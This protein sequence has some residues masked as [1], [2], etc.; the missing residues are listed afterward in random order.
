MNAIIIGAGPAGLTAAYELLTRTSIKPIVLE[1]SSD[2]GGL[3]KTVNHN[4]NR[5]DI[6]GHRFFSKSDR[7]MD[8]W[9]RFLPLQ[10]VE[11]SEEAIFYQGGKREV[12]GSGSGPDP[13]LEDDVMLLRKRA[14]RIYYLAKLFPYPVQPGLDLALKL[15]IKRSVAILASYLRVLVFPPRQVK[16]LEEFFISRFGKKLYETFFKSYTEKVWGVPCRELSAD[17]GAQRVKKLSITKAIWHSLRKVWPFRKV[18]DRKQLETSLIEQFLYPKFGPGQMWET[19]AREIIRLG[20]VIHRN[21]EVRTVNLQGQRVLSLEAGTRGDPES[22]TYQADY[23]ISTMPIKELMRA[24][25]PAPPQEMA[26]ISEGLIYRDFVTVGLLL[27]HL[28]LGQVGD[29][30]TVKDN[31]IYIHEPSVEAGRLQIFNNWSPYM[32][33]DP[34][35]AWVGVEYFCNEGDRIWSRSDA[36][37]IAHTLDELFRIGIIDERRASDAVVV[38]MKKAYPAYRGTYARFGELRRHL[39][40]IENLYLV[41]RNGMHRYN[42]QDHSMLTA[43]TAVD[44][45]VEGR[46][47]RANIWD[48]NS[49]QDYH[50]ATAKVEP[51]PPKRTS[52]TSATQGLSPSSRS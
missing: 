24:I 49:E 26:D 21:T 23:C 32:V 10:K 9:F 52:N 17:W 41:G 36:E 50:E 38:R 4:D 5:I 39:D 3:S 40:G 1:A 37:M 30:G 14:S 46:T 43:M 16:T 44:N 33:K 6:G 25:D 31:W 27:D 18:G 29:S 7:V 47:D 34:E 48:V 19:V 22:R 15:G 13:S 12:V 28:R 8:W 45:I 42:N 35:R 11:N 51:A 2:L 20:G